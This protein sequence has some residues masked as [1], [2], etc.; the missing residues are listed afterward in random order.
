MV[1]QPALRPDSP[2]EH[3]S[4]TGPSGRLYRLALGFAVLFHLAHIMSLPVVVSY[5]GFWYIRLAEILGTEQF[6]AEWDYLRTPL[7]P[8]LLKTAFWVLG[9]QPLAAIAAASILG[10]LGIWSLADALKRAGCPRAAAAT[11]VL[12]TLYPV[13]VGYEHCVLSESG[14]FF[15]LALLLNVLTWETAQQYR[16]TAALAGV[17]AVGYYFRPTLLYLAPVAAV[18]HAVGLLRGEEALAWRGLVTAVRQ[19]WRPALLHGAAVVLLPAVAAHPWQVKLNQTNRTTDMVVFGLVQ[20]IVVP[21]DDPRLADVRAEY[22]N[23]IRGSLS[24]GRLSFNGMD[25][26]QAFRFSAH[27]KS[28]LTV[29]GTVLYREL[30]LAHPVRWAKGV[31]RATLLYCG[32]PAK[33]DE[34]GLFRDRVLSATETGSKIFP[35]PPGL[36]ERLRPEF[37]QKTGDPLAARVLRLLS[38]VYDLLVFLGW[39]VTTGLFLAALIRLDLRLLAF[40]TL[41]LAFCLMHALLMISINRHAFPCYPLVLANLCVLGGL[42]WGRLAS[43]ARTGAAAAPPDAAAN[44]CALRQDDAPSATVQRRAVAGLAAV[45]ITLGLC[46]TVYLVR[47]GMAPSWDE[48]H[49]MGGVLSITRGVQTGSLGEAWEAYASALGIKPP[50]ICLPAVPLALAAGPSTLTSMLSLV[51]VLAGIVLAAYSLFRNCL[52]P[53]LALAGAALLATM[54]LVTGLTHRFYV[55]NHLL[56]LSLV[57]LDLLVRHGWRTLRWAA[58]AG[59]V[60]GLG[61]LGKST[62]LPLVF[63]STVYLLFVELREHYGGPAFKR[64]AALVFARASF[65]AGLAFLVAWTWYARHW[66]TVLYWNSLAIWHSPCAYPT[67]SSFLANISSGPHLFVFCLAL[68]GLPG[69]VRALLAGSLAPR[70]ARAW[71][72]ILLLAGFS[73]FVTAVALAKQIRY[74]VLWLPA[75]AALAAAALALRCGARQR[76]LLAAGAAVACSFLLFLH[77]SFELLPVRRIAVGDLKLVDCRFPLNVPDWFDDNHPVDPRDFRQAEA[78]ALIAADTAGKCPAG[79]TVRV[80]LAGDG[81]LWSHDCFGLLAALQGHKAEYL[82]WWWGGGAKVEGPEAPD[83]IVQAC[84]FERIYP[85][86]QNHNWYPALE[87]H[88]AEG[89]LGYELLARLAAPADTALLIFRKKETRAQSAP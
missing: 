86:H 70:A 87:S 25:S 59:V 66:Q 50:L 79:Q 8:F 56:L 5:D 54:P 83:Y 45:I 30:L 16:K 6:S 76:A 18:L 24:H 11:L 40:T 48:A 73:F 63:P 23:A 80:R 57:Y 38:P 64:E 13:L 75:L 55:E 22:E 60:L 81:L 10:F 27:L 15:F 43:T 65:M 31:T 1:D 82:P 42:W 17:I 12:L 26:H 72:A 20:Q 53:G 71:V 78:V 62:F 2:E 88:V 67:V 4:V 33:E 39:L 44:P 58:L 19:R 89:R 69:V 21:P 61:L 84:G 52:S 74:T 51:L 49:Y 41:P 85:G 14:T 9:R 32:L 47:S 77:N 36:D 46:H 29:P 35:G 7:F 68:A 3:A 37:A 34:N 28:R